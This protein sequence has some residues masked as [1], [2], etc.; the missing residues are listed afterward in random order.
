MFIANLYQAKRTM[1]K[2]CRKQLCE[3]QPQN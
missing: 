1:K 3:R 2:I